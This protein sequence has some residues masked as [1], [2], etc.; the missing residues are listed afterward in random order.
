MSDCTGESK[1]T[2]NVASSK[3][4]SDGADEGGIKNGAGPDFV[5]SLSVI[6]QVELLAQALLREYMHRRG[7]TKTLRTFDTECPRNERTISSRQLMRQLLEI[8]SNAFPSRLSG[9]DA[10]DDGKAKKKKKSQPTFMEEL[11]SYRVQKREFEQRRQAQ[12]EGSAD[13]DSGRTIDAIDP[14]DAEMEEL[15]SAALN[16]ERLIEEKKQRDELLL[17]RLEQ[18][19]EEKRKSKDEDGG[20]NSKKAK[21][22][23]LGEKHAFDPFG[24]DGEGN[25]G[26]GGSFFKR[27]HAK[28]Q[29]KW[30]HDVGDDD[31]DNGLNSAGGHKSDGNIGKGRSSG[32]EHCLE[33]P[34]FLLAS[35]ETRK[36]NRS[37]CSQVGSGWTPGGNIGGVGLSSMSMMPPSDAALSRPPSFL[38][39]DGM[40]LMTER[41]QP[42]TKPSRDAWKPPISMPG[43]LTAVGGN[44]RGS[45]GFRGES[46]KPGTASTAS[47]L[48]PLT[49][50]QRGINGG[51]TRFHHGSTPSL[52][53]LGAP[54]GSVGSKAGKVVAPQTN[55]SVGGGILM[56]S[57]E[58]VGRGYD[59]SL[60]PATSALRQSSGTKV[61]GNESGGDAGTARKVRRVTILVD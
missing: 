29:L 30:M 18:K 27:T 57:T 40:S 3:A 49:F 35:M 9:G 21:Q 14:S 19:R 58:A 10:D 24:S 36:G 43:A 11:C 28:K 20:R 54:L 25:D 51:A 37:G 61:K 12:D 6:E 42:D 15:R 23:D 55:P 39:G 50:G 7:Y 26:D 16:T 60:R 32:R 8:P 13:S 31:S 2:N 52:D 46:V 56:H 38:A 47:P 17:E 45:A 41:M 59:G 53:C 22:G 5:G 1:Q 34:E 4:K 44:L 48:G 33:E